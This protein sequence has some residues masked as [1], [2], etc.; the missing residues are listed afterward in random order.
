MLRILLLGLSVSIDSWAV[1]ASYHA[2]D[3]RIPRLTKVIMAVVSALVGLAA[4]LAGDILDE[5]INTTI[6]E[7]AGGVLLVLLGIKTLWGAVAKREEK[8]FDRDCS[9][10][11]EPLE[12]ILLG[13]ALASDTL[14]AGLS[15]WGIG[16][17]AYAFPFAVGGLNFF[18]LQLAQ[19]RWWG[20]KICDYLGGG[21]LIIMGVAAVL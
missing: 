21:I 4:V 9:K 14:C 18:F 13:I 5:F 8:N 3:I 7:R 19:K 10:N 11:I 20:T 12:G 6:V 17:I 2:A 15:L 16:A 1:G